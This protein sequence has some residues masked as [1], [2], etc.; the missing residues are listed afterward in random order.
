MQE[1]TRSSLLGLFQA[2][3]TVDAKGLREELGSAL[4]GQVA[5]RLEQSREMEYSGR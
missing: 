2:E 4:E 1:W 3:E 5:G